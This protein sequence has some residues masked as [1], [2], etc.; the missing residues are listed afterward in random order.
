VLSLSG[1]SREH[2]GVTP[3]IEMAVDYHGQQ[4]N[5]LLKL[6]TSTRPDR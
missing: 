5:L 3:L 4:L 6:E 1:T 2:L